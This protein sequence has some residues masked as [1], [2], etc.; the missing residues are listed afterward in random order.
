[1]SAVISPRREA[2][3]TGYEAELLTDYSFEERSQTEAHLL[4]QNAGKIGLMGNVMVEPT[5]TLA[6][7]IH[8]AAE[9]DHEALQMLMINA[10]KDI[11]ER[12]IKSGHVTDI[13]MEVDEETDELKQF[14]QTLDQVNANAWLYASDDK[15][16]GPRTL[17]ETRNNKRNKN[18]LREG[19]LNDNWSVTFSMCDDML[20][21]KE[22]DELGFF[23]L[24]KSMSI[25]A[26]TIIDGK[27][28]TQS[29]FVAGVKREGEPRH[30]RN[31]M[32][33]VGEL[34][35]I[36]LDLSATELLDRPVIISKD[37]M[38]DVTDMVALYDACAGTFFGEDKLTQDYAAYRKK[39]KD[40]EA[41]L[42]H[43]VQ[44]VVRELIASR[45]K[46]HDAIDAVE[47]LATLSQQAM[48]EEAL[49]NTDIDVR[50]FGTKAAVEL[51]EARLAYQAG[52]FAEAQSRLSTAQK[53]ASS[54]SCPSKLRRTTKDGRE[55]MEGELD[56][57][58]EELDRNWKTGMC[59][60]SKCPTRPG[61][62]MVGPCNICRGCENKYNEGINPETYYALKSKDFRALEKDS[63]K[64]AMVQQGIKEVLSGF[65]LLLGKA[66]Q[67]DKS[68]S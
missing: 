15:V 32:A 6:D 50:V 23:S 26:T 14:G 31:T 39:C 64:E 35:G 10:R 48:V 46:V 61:Q 55:L 3:Y 65:E 2:S 45:H 60:T 1:M 67:S 38:S 27:V 25:Q 54:S 16:L 33:K 11:I 58:E 28:V 57:D 24:T 5:Y 30:D 20:D 21:D 47:L 37:Q 36:D 18:A 41:K 68:S 8:K 56:P 59:R 4:I 53:V 52:N 34:L 49:T 42:E 62:T 63:S 9:G 43:R 12:V 66:A 19:V 7:A 44:M 22:L 17:A 51:T 29:A 13:E 40:R